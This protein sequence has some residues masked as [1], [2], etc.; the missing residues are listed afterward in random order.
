M[1]NVAA[2]KP[3]VTVLVNDAGQLALSANVSFPRVK[4]ILSAM[5]NQIIQD[6]AKLQIKNESKIIKPSGF[7]I[8]GN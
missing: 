6:E 3:R 8:G 1:N 5:L 2:N 7:R 4:S